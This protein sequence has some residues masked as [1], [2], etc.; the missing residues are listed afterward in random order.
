MT[1]EEIE[2]IIDAR[3]KEKLELITESIPYAGE[4]M[5]VKYDDVTL[6]ESVLLNS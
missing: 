1:K 4:Y 6:G 2:A 3:I 5:E